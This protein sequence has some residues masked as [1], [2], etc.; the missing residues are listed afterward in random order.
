MVFFNSS[1]PRSGATLLQNILGQHPGI[2]V[3]PTDGFL[4]LIYAARVNFTNNAEFQAQDQEQMLAAW[5]GFCRE[6]LKGY[7][8]GLSDKPNTCIKSQGI[9]EQFNWFEAFMG[10]APKVIVMVRNVKSVLSSMEK[11]HRANS[12]KAQQVHNP[13]EMRG[14]TT[15]SRVQQWLSGPPVGLALQR[16]QQM[17]QQ[18]T[19]D[20]CLVLR[21][22]DLTSKPD[23]VM[24]K[25]YEYLGLDAFA[26]DFKNVEQITK[27][28]D[29]VYGLTPNLQL[30][31]KEVEE[32]T[33]DYQDI[34]GKP[35]CKWIE[36]NC[37]G[38]QEDYGY[39]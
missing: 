38:Y 8:D 3:T 18:G 34:L 2:H 10:E 32:V 5:R 6:G 30:V 26:H 14:L 19:I 22:E 35:L 11:M 24:A 1:M 15:E 17:S 29:A 9:G 36:Q 39:A 21:F 27:E 16:L 28:D 37:A 20:K 13:L 4:E 12:E 23:A 25:V 33:P 7:V 31:R